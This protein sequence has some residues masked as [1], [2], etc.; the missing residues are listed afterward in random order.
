VNT[1]TPFKG[2]VSA[3]KD[4]FGFSEGQGLREFMLETK[5]LTDADKAEIKVG[6]EKLGYVIHV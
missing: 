4:F 2:L 5:Q 3:M 6:L 1:A